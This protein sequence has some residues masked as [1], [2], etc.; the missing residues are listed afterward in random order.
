MSGHTFSG[1]RMTSRVGAVVD[2]EHMAGIVRKMR[3]IGACLGIALLAASVV[4]PSMN[5]GFEWTAYHG[6][7]ARSSSGTG[8]SWEATG[9]LVGAVFLLGPFATGWAFRQSAGEVLYLDG[10]RLTVVRPGRRAPDVFD[11]ARARSEVRLDKVPGSRPGSAEAREQVGS[12]RPVLV[13]RT[14]SGREA[15][16]ELANQRSR[17]M[18]LSHETRMLADAM[19][20]TTDPGVGHTAGQLRTVLRWTK[21]PVI[22]DAAPDAIPASPEDAASSPIPR[23]RVAEG[24][25]GPELE[26][27]GRG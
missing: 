10:T 7:S 1:H 9:V 11:L 20:F 15:V 21:L 25:A 26:I 17:A 22:H 2:P 4:L 8:L 14:E 3:I 12:Y 19:R 27:T 23:T 18:R 5:G 13:L 6:A 24:V 16:I